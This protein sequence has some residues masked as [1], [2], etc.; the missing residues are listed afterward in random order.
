MH[1]VGSFVFFCVVK[2]ETLICDLLFSFSVFN[3]RLQF[4]KTISLTLR[5]WMNSHNWSSW[6][7]SKFST[8]Q[9]SSSAWFAWL[10]RSTHV[11]ATSAPKS[12]AASV[13]KRPTINSTPVA[14]H[15]AGDHCNHIPWLLF[16]WR[17]GWENLFKGEINLDENIMPNFPRQDASGGG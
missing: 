1:V 8:W 13:S 6:L 12:S 3:Q 7:T 14:V 15:I 10:I 17:D 4:F 16:C 11:S 5:K 2:Q 9:T